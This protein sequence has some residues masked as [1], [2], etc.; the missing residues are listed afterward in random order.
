MAVG[1][2]CIVYFVFGLCELEIGLK[3]IKNYKN[4]KFKL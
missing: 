3:K 4:L 2:V 1:L